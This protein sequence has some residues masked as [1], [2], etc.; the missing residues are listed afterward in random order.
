MYVE[1]SAESVYLQKDFH[2]VLGVFH[3]EEA[4]APPE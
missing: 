4:L 1:K 3:L 2:P